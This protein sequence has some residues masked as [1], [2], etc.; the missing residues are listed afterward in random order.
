MKADVIVL[1]E[2]D[3]VIVKQFIGSMPPK[4]VDSYAKKILPKLG[5]IFGKGRV[6]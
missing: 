6:A 5:S 1:K 2:N 4:D 3:E